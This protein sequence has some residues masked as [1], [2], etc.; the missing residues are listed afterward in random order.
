[1]SSCAIPSV[2]QKN[3]PPAWPSVTMSWPG[4]YTSSRA[5]FAT[6][7]SWDFESPAKSGT[8]RSTSSAFFDR[9]KRDSSPVAG[10]LVC[11]L[12][13]VLPQNAHARALPARGV[14]Y[15]APS[16]SPPPPSP[17]SGPPP[18]TAQPPPMET[19]VNLCKR[20]GIIFPNSEIYGGLRSTWDYGPLGVELKN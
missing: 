4:E 16:M 7:L 19:I 3:G 8:D 5:S 12:G 11:H 6:R 2:M 13:A 20:R 15:D 14:R 10:R 1:M 17:P 18:P 9:D